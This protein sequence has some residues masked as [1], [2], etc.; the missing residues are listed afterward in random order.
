MK[1][2]TEVRS[3]GVIVHKIMRP[4]ETCFYLVDGDSSGPWDYLSNA[5]AQADLMKPIR[6]KKHAQR[7]T[8]K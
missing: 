3:N 4:D 2:G 6:K 1:H 5:R 7:D 8:R